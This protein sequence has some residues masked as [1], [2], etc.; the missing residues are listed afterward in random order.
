MFWSIEDITNLIKE[1]NKYYILNDKNKK[2]Y[3]IIYGPMQ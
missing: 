3:E 1:L 2:E